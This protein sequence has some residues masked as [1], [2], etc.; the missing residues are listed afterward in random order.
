MTEARISRI[1][2][3]EDPALQAFA[4][5]IANGLMAAGLKAA[6]H[7]A[8]PK[9]FAL[10]GSG[11]L[12]QAFLGYLRSRPLEAQQKLS[13]KALP[14]VSNKQV[15][16]LEGIDLAGARPALD[17][18]MERTK[19]GKISAGK[20]IAKSEAPLLEEGTLGFRQQDAVDQLQF[21]LI[22]VKCIDETDGLLASEAGSDE[23]AFGGLMV[24]AAGTS[25]SIPQFRVGDFASDGVVKDFN[26]PVKFGTM[27]FRSGAGWPKTFN[28]VLTLVELDNGNFP[29]LLQKLVD[30]ARAKITGA[31]NGVI[32]E[33]P[34]SISEAITAAL[35]WVLDK[36]FGWL[37]AWWED[38]LFAPLTATFRFD[39]ADARW[40]GQS[41]TAPLWFEWRGH[42]GRYKLWYKAKLAVAAEAA[43]ASGAIVYEHSNYGGKSALLP[44]GHYT[45]AQ[46]RARGMDND[47]ISSI[48][49]G[50]GMRVVAYQHEGFEG[51]ARMYTG[52]IAQLADFND[53]ITSIVVEPLRV[54]LFQHQNF[55]GGSQ[56]FGPGRYDV[57]QLTV[58][59][60]SASSVLV[61]PG[62]KVTLFSNA[63]FQGTKKVITGDA[64]YVGNDFNDIV[65]S[66]IVELV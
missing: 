55:G 13:A 43:Q 12:E 27:D 48:K 23:I 42:G 62:Y 8:S 63:K 56:A 10:P 2:K 51:V 11:S 16:G 65:S 4:Q 5:S 40:A 9:Q 6:A 19:L 60:D 64:S 33:L 57:G 15:P 59:N 25:I 58:G 45:L 34:S 52:S 54:M 38:D 49:V 3:I 36:V 46:M 21:H 26:P 22:S 1:T 39:S 31:V 47:K 24:D 41:E 30:E 61:P 28:L 7:H 29:A 66:L 44:V 50:A 32:S 37:A 17:L 35:D 53:Q 18:V 14:V 20:A